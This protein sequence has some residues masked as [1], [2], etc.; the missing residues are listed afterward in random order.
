[1]KLQ[2]GHDFFFINHCSI[3]ALW[4]LCWHGRLELQFGFE[5]IPQ[6]SEI[7]YFSVCI[8]Y[9]L[10]LCGIFYGMFGYYL[11]GFLHFLY[12]IIPTIK[13]TIGTT[14]H[15]MIM[16]KLAEE[17]VIPGPGPQ[18]ILATLFVH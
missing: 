12:K 3:Q 18:F 13:K 16:A 2:I 11:L 6:F 15:G 1:M 10:E 14:T 17:V 7:N 4:K 9:W 5:H 8:I